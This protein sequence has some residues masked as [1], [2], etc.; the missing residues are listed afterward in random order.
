MAIS[1]ETDKVKYP[2]GEFEY[3]E[4]MDYET[5]KSRIQEIESLPLRLARE[6]N[7]LTR[8]QLNTPYRS[9]G[10][11]V[12]Q[13]VH[14]LADSHMNGYIRLKWALTEDTPTIKPYNQDAWAGT[15][16]N[17]LFPVSDALDFLQLLHKKWVVLLNALDEQHLDRKFDHPESGEYDLRKS[18]ALYAWHGNHHLAQIKGLIE[19]KRW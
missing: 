8:E 10:W 5:I 1:I 3:N 6:V 14:H 7:G 12:R 16:E 9:G 15:P 11:S 2:I 4:P 18:I 17:V 19:R 13:V